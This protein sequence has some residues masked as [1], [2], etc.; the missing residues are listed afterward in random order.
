MNVMMVTMLM[1][2]DALEIVISS[3]DTL[4]QVVLQMPKII[5]T[6]SNQDK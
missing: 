1:E 5:V 6:S 2:M 4:V 3:K